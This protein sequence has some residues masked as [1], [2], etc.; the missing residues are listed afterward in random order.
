MDNYRIRARVN[1]PILKG[2][3]RG[4]IYSMEE[5]K[6]ISGKKGYSII[7]TNR[8]RINVKN[9]GESNCFNLVK[10]D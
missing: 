5:I 4:V 8:K 2:F 7:A 9:G 6:S 3:R 10:E 1:T